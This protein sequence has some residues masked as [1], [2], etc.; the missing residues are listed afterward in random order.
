MQVRTAVLADA[1]AI[2]RLINLA[3]QVE[4][5]F[6]DGDRIGIE[7]VQQRLGT[8]RF[9]LAEDANG[10]AGCAYVE[11][12]SERSY[13]G[14]LSV[15]PARQKSGIGKQ[16]V[17]AAEECARHAGCRF[18]DLR[19]V[20]LREELPGFYSR[21]GY[22]EDGTSAFPEHAHPKQP[23]HFVNMSKPLQ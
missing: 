8:G 15:D 22:V 12:Q 7:E 19:I 3:F 18:M 1:D 9:L 6:M 5:F 17:F 21:L 10:L 20:N 14:L 2:T 4:R 13:L 23:C 16:L 11:L